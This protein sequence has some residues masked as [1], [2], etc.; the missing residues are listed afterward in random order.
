VVPRGPFDLSICGRCFGAPVTVGAPRDGSLPIGLLR[1]WRDDRLMR[2]DHARYSNS[3]Q[4]AG[5]GAVH[6]LRRTETL[7]LL[8]PRRRCS[9]FGLC[10]WARPDRL[11]RHPAGSGCASQ[12]TRRAAGHWL[13][14]RGPRMGGR[15]MLGPLPR[16]SLPAWER[17]IRFYSL[18]SG[19]EPCRGN[20]GG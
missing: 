19:D 14:W 16:A 7:P 20:S 8:V 17:R 1:E 3:D 4:C 2:I 9:N 11:D 10:R 13:V 6:R 5:Q 18:Q 12:G 15:Q